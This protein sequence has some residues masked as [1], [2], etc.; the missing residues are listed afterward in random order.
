MACVHNL[1]LVLGNSQF[2][3]KQGATVHFYIIANCTIIDPLCLMRLFRGPIHEMLY[4]CNERGEIFR[5]RL[6]PVDVMPL[7][8]PLYVSFHVIR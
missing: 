5:V 8:I 6:L 4:S 1:L 2:L 7:N 3:K